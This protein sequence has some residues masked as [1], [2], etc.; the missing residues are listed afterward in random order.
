MNTLLTF[1]AG[2]AAGSLTGYGHQWLARQWAKVTKKD[3]AR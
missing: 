2:F 1:A 3:K